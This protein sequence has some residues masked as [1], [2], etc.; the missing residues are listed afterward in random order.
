MGGEDDRSVLLPQRLQP[1]AKLA[2]E[3]AVVEREP[4][5]VDD[6]QGGAAIEPILDTMEQVGE[7]CGRRAR[8]D[9]SLGLERLDL[10]FAQ[11]LVFRVEQS[12]PR[13]PD[14]IRLQRLLQRIRL[15]QD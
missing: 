12:P 8:P 3:A 6:K 1:F 2:G 9:Q 14:R 15:Q 7:D 11:A 5:L 13:T 4:A 10:C